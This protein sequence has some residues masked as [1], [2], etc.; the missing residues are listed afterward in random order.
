VPPS[1]SA[2]MAAGYQTGINRILREKMAAE[3]LT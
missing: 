1:S 3:A 2:A